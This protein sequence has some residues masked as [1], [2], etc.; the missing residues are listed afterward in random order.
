[1]ILYFIGGDYFTNTLSQAHVFIRFNG[2]RPKERKKKCIHIILH[3]FNLTDN[4]PLKRVAFLQFVSDNIYH[5]QQHQP[6]QDVAIR[7]LICSQL[8]IPILPNNQTFPELPLF[9]TVRLSIKKSIPESYP[10]E[11][12]DKFIS[13]SRLSIEQ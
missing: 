13:E 11:L 4:M 6:S 3:T 8:N 2:V 10:F 5:P 9:S 12:C 7:F 1:M